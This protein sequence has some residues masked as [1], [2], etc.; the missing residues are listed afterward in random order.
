MPVRQANELQ[1]WLP[2]AEV[3][4]FEGKGEERRALQ[5]DAGKVQVLL[6]HHDLAAHDLALLCKVGCPS[7]A[8]T[9]PAPPRPSFLRILPLS[10]RPSACASQA[11]AL[12]LIYRDIKYY[13][14]ILYVYLFIYIYLYFISLFNKLYVAPHTSDCLFNL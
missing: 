10:P 1:R 11:A 6:T 5:R 12:V 9:A 3:V 7:A 13:V 14:Y 2:G 8:A 4:L